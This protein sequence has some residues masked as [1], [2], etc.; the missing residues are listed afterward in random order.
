MKLEN[1]KD[2]LLEQLNDLYSAEKQITDALPKMA[3]KAT[4]EDLAAAFESHMKETEGQMERLDKAFKAMDESPKR[5]KCK[6]ME[7][8]IEEGEHFMKKK[9]DPD[10]M[11]AGLIAAAQRVEHYEIAGYGTAAT[12]AKQLGEEKVLKLLLETLNEEK[13]TDEKLT[14]LAK[15]CINLNAEA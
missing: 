4:N 13:V 14:K 10:V 6:A 7:G 1:L 8:I 9:A 2:L 5:H 12:Y 11:D 15:T 3:K